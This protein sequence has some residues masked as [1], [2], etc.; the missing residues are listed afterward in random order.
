MSR[1]VVITGASAG[2]GRA[3]AR[4]FAA[5]GDHVALL[6]RGEEGLAAAAHEVEAAGG[7]ALVLPHDV[8]D[9]EAVDAAAQ[10]V[11]A[12]M[13]PIDVWVNNAMATVFAPIHR[14]RADEYRRVTEVTYLGAV[15]GTLSALKQM[16]PRDCGVIIQVGSALAY[17]SIPLQSAYCAAKHA[18]L[19]FTESLHTELIH[20]GSGIHLTTVHLPALNTPQFVWSRSRMSHMPQPVPPIYQPEVA[21]EAIEW[22]SRACRRE[23]WV[24]PPTVMTILADRLAP[25]L[26]DR[27]L[28]N[29][30]YESQFT[31]QPDP[32][33]RPDN[34]YA[35]LP[36]DFGAEGPFNERARSS[37][38]QLKL[39][40]RRAVVAAGAAA[41]LAAI[42]FWRR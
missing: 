10:R 37:S 32:G 23:V 25:G 28:G 21:A 20:D 34:L 30:G 26:L 31:E 5:A 40:Q 3:T 41:A 2:V 42:L 15:Y 19:G 33:D 9:P 4:R 7:R 12:E 8:A 14:T 36:G 22:A 29:K 13:G 39:T 11:E 16:R 1:V 27:Y 18:L 17:R 24:G 6:A 35:P 38:L